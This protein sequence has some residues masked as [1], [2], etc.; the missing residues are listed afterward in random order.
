MDPLR[1]LTRSPTIVSFQVR[2][3]YAKDLADTYEAIYSSIIASWCSFAAY[4][5]AYIVLLGHTPTN[6]DIGAYLG[7]SLHHAGQRAG[8]VAI[9]DGQFGVVASKRKVVHRIRPGIRRRD[10]E[11]EI[12]R[13]ILLDAVWSVLCKPDYDAVKAAADAY[14]VFNISISIFSAADWTAATSSSVMGSPR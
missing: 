12:G 3:P 6:A 14:R 13:A 4:F 9:P 10:Q 2:I 7:E 8:K 5:L 1:K 11:D